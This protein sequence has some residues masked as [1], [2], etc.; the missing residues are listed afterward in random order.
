MVTF[1]GE[2]LMRNLKQ[3]PRPVAGG[4]IGAGGAAM[5]EVDEDLLAVFED[6]VVAR[7]VDVDHGPDAT[8]IV[9]VPR[10]VQTL[11]V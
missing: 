9:L 8:G 1:R 4:F 2:E 5:S 3:N 6:G 7:A 10:L 11:I